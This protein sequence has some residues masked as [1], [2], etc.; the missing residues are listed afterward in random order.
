[1]RPLGLRFPPGPLNPVDAVWSVI[2]RHIGAT[3]F[4]A[5]RSQ[6]VFGI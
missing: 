2:F 5:Y 1:M 6:P 3:E 4:S